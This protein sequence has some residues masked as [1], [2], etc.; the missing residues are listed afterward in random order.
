MRKI[1][2]FERSK[3]GCQKMKSD[4][5]DYYVNLDIAGMPDA[6]GKTETETI[7]SQPTTEIDWQSEAGKWAFRFWISITLGVLGLLIFAYVADTLDN[8]II[9]LKQQ[10]ESTLH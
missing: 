5:Q 2:V 3:S 10:I 9:Q 7:V 6:R 8:E 1:D 4:A